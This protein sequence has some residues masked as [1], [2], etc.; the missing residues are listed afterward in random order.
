VMAAC[1]L[2][3]LC[4][5][6]ETKAP[7]SAP[8]VGATHAGPGVESA[9]AGAVAAIVRIRPTSMPMD[10]AAAIPPRRARRDNPRPNNGSPDYVLPGVT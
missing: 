3:P 8:E 1:R 4:A 7:H 10:V 9:E 2:A 5:S 6:T